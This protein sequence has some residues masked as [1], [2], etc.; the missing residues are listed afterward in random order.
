MIPFESK[1]DRN[2]TSE[3]TVYIKTLGCKVNTFDSHALENQFRALGW[4]LV[5]EPADAFV[6]VINTCSVTANADKEARYLARRFRKESPESLVVMTGCYAQTDSARLRE[7]SEVDI[8]VPNEAK[9]QTVSFVV[10]QSVARRSGLPVLK[11]PLGAK[12]VSANKQQHFKSSITLFDQ[13]S[14]TQTRAF[15]K[16][17]D[18]CN[19]FCT[20]CLIPYARGASRSVS[21]MDALTEIRRLVSLGTKEI[22]L[23]GIH[24]G[25]FGEDRR[26]DY[27]SSVTEPFVEFMKRVFDLDGLERVR[28]SSLEPAELT[29]SLIKVLSEHSDRFCDHFHLPLQ[30]GCDDILKKM[31]RKYDKA[32]YLE[33][34]LMAKEYF[35]DVCLGADVIPG[36]PS[37]TNEQFMETM[38]FIRSC[39][40]NYLHVFPYS[41]RPNTAAVKMPGHLD[42]SVIKSRAKVLRD[43]SETL[44]QNYRAKFFGQSVDVLWENKLDEQGRRLGLTKNY[45]N[46]TAALGFEMPSVGSITRATLKGFASK[47]QLLATPGLLQ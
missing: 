27:D 3:K 4:H 24:I 31:R 5:S 9:E 8:V 47:D 40:L 33:S 2:R 16:I 28:I 1:P 12:A 10:E 35:P 41:P 17:Q 11:M 22:V 36:F 13:A 38:D 19:G 46:V 45:L 21:E 30:S 15:V 44:M 25:D 23:T 18:G 39:G 37:E 43:L 20:Y 26:E 14:S 6:N 29:E 7:M 42:G 34:C 32:R